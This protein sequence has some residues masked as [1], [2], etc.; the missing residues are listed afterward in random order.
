MDDLVAFLGNYW[1]LAF[2]LF[3]L[4]MAASGR[5]A[6]N[7]RE[8]H[9]QRLERMAAQQR[10]IE[11]QAAA[12]GIA[13]GTERAAV[14]AAPSASVSG[15]RGTADSIRD[16][17]IDLIA[18]HDEITARWMDYELDVAKLI[19]FP[20]MSDGRQ[21]L[22][23]AFLVAKRKADTLRPARVDSPMD[24]ERL[25]AY[26]DAVS[27]YGAAF[28]LAE[29]DAKR[30]RDAGFAPD[31]RDR[32]ERAAKMLRIAIDESATAAERQIA[33]RRVRQEI[34]G[35]IV[36]SP[37]SISILESKVGRELTDAAGG[38]SAPAGETMRPADPTPDADPLRPPP[39]PA[40][41]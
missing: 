40:S 17:V 28:D 34:D 8:R 36:L 32:L 30:V 39:P 31:E 24:S 25:A 12:G 11:A 2:P 14:T 41:A 19:A 3:G 38:A 20:A 15:A 10:L 35:L 22:T 4:G 5:W 7:R 16:Q 18:A 1:W 33:Y 29:N 6:S 9:E 26:R 37:A 27:A 13:P 21:P 23:A